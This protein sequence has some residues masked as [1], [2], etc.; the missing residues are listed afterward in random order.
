[1]N[2]APPTP[3]TI[4]KGFPTFTSPLLIDSGGFK[5]VYKVKHGKDY[6]ALKL[7]PLPKITDTEGNEAFQKEIIGR[8]KRELDS[9]QKCNIPEL[10]HLGSLSL[11]EIIIS[12]KVFLAYSEEFLDGSNL[13]DLLR[14][15]PKK[16][17]EKELRT[18]FLALLKAIRKLWDNGYV[19][20]DIKPKNIIKLN[21]ASRQF[22]LL[23]LGIAYSVNDTS[24]TIN[25]HDRLPPA[26]LRYLAPEM[27]NANF[28]EN[29]DYRSDLYTAAM[30]VYEYGA[31]VHPLAKDQ[32]DLMQTISRALHQEPRPLAELRPDLSEEF[33][34]LIDQ[35]LKKKPALRPANLGILI[36]KM[37]AIK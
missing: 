34:E 18:L 13:W 7:I 16:P 3:D 8:V 1:M 27:M 26:T 20:R 22:V 11:T 36:H 17:D 29:I 31:K 10:V 30:S 32:D 23:D 37:E 9:L 21:D 6:E 15:D 5:V 4:Q 2:I 24:L 14:K 35:M 33:R 28:R 12:D 25:P 19:H